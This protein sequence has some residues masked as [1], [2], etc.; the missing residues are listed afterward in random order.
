MGFLLIQSAVLL[1]LAVAVQSWV[2]VKLIGPWTYVKHPYG[3]FW[4]S[5]F[6]NIKLSDGNC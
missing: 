1:V 3:K 4:F 2:P 6:Y 5:W